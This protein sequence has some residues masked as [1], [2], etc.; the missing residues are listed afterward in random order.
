MIYGNIILN[1]RIGYGL[2]GINKTTDN[3][4]GSDKWSHLRVDQYY[5]RVVGLDLPPGSPIQMETSGYMEEE[6]LR[7]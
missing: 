3:D 1:N 5:I 7:L 6:P 4:F 2:Q